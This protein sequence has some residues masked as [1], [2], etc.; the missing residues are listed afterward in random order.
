MEYFVCGFGLRCASLGREKPT[1]LSPIVSCVLK[2]RSLHRVQGSVLPNRLASAHPNSPYRSRAAE[3]LRVW[4]VKMRSSPLFSSM[5]HPKC[6][7][8][9][10]RTMPESSSQSY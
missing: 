2:E 1:Q 8:E 9:H 6:A 7:S 3:M 4:N 10:A 5:F